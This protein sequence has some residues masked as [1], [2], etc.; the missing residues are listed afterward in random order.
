M[1]RALVA[2]PQEALYNGTWYIAWVLSVGCPRVGLELVQPTDIKR[3][4]YTKCRL[5]RPPEDE[6]VMLETCKDS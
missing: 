3:T 2:H 5:F 6:Q 1:F 4:Q